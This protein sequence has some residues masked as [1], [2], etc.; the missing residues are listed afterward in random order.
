MPLGSWLR[1]FACSPIRKPANAINSWTISGATVRSGRLAQ[2]RPLGELTGDRVQFFVGFEAATVPQQLARESKT[3]LEPFF[4]RGCAFDLSPI[5]GDLPRR[6][7]AE[8]ATAPRRS[9][10]TRDSRSSAISAVEELRTTRF[11][12]GR[13]DLLEGE[14]VAQDLQ[15]DEHQQSRCVF[16]PTPNCPRAPERHTAPSGF[17]EQQTQ[18]SSVSDPRRARHAKR[19]IPN[20][21]A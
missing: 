20:G 4:R 17:P 8:V 12:D 6:V 14:R 2:T 19:V 21:F 10:C 16:V 13:G 1:Q 5:R 9:R 7:E 15:R 11:G 18:L 3:Q